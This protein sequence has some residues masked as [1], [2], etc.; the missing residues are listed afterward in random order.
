MILSSEG[1]CPRSGPRNLFSCTFPHF[2]S[3]H[4]KECLMESIEILSIPHSPNCSLRIFLSF[5][6]LSTFLLSL[7]LFP[8]FFPFPS[9][10]FPFPLFSLLNLLLPPLFPFPFLPFPLF[11]LL[12]FPLSL[13]R[14]LSFSFSFLP[15]LVFSS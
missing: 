5:P 12:T 6:S 4:F 8:D 1:D 11:S 10:F 14:F 3:S 13:P 15:S 9:P 2:L 7:F